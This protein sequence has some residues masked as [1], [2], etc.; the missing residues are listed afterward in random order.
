MK[1]KSFI[2]FFVNLLIGILFSIPCFSVQS[3][4]ENQSYILLEYQFQIKEFE[5]NSISNSKEQD[6]KFYLKYKLYKFLHVNFDKKVY[7]GSNN[8]ETR[9]FLSSKGF[10]G[11]LNSDNYFQLNKEKLTYVNLSYLKELRTIKMLC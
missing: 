3:I 4:F 11:K 5:L 2:S 8:E 9:I 6:V 1:N 10:K 7:D